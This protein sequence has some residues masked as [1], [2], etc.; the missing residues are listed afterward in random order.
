[1]PLPKIVFAVILLLM[2]ALF[3]V[4]PGL[5]RPD[6]FFAVTVAPDFRQTDDARRILR[7]FWMIVWT[8]TL[9]AILVELATGLALV[10]L[11][12]L[13]AGFLGALVT[14]HG[15][16]LAYTA[17]PSSV[18]EI[19]LA[20]PREGLPG[21][22][23]VALLPVFALAVLAAWVGLNWDR[24]PPRFPVH[25]GFQGPDRWVTTN[26]GTVFGF[27]ALQAF[28][29]LLLAGSAWGVLNLSRRV[30]TSGARAASERHFRRRV[31]QLMIVAEFFVACPAWFALFQPSGTIMNVWGAA[32]AVIM[33]IF[34]VNLIHLGQGGSR[35]ALPASAEADGD[36]T[37]DACWKWGVFYFNPADPAILI[38]KRFGIGYTLN[39]GNRWSW[40]VL[41]VLILVPLALAGLLLR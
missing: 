39:L 19:N 37:P 15:R 41:A 8:S 38:E 14:S 25:W 20:A 28:L 9:A 40:G 1:M 11:L 16:V 3:S 17:A 26:P 22:P 10:S 31:V 2:G 30:S 29:C 12:I 13:A 5:T 7:R 27:F 35:D 18:V 33:L 32:L 4:V 24:L 36:H 21:G 34:A 23:I 6:L